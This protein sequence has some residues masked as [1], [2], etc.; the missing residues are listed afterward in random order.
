MRARGTLGRCKRGVGDAVRR[1]LFDNECLRDEYFATSYIVPQKALLGVRALVF[2]Y[3]TAVLISNLAANIVHGAGWNWAA[4]F[5]TLTYSGITAYYGFA[6]YN[7]ARHLARCRG[8]AHGRRRGGV[9]GRLISP[10]IPLPPDQLLLLAAASGRVFGTPAALALRGSS[11]DCERKLDLDHVRLTYPSAHQLRQHSG[12][13][14]EALQWLLR[15]PRKSARHQLSLAA[16]WILYELFTCYAPLVSLVYWA[17]LYPTQGGLDGAA[18]TW[19]GV[20]MHGANT[21]LMGLEVFVFARCPYRWTHVSVV[22]GVLVAYLALVYLMVG[23]YDF[24]VYPFFESKYFG[25][26]GVAVV[27]LLV[28]DVVAIAWVVLLMVHRWRDSAYPRRWLA[29]KLASV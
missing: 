22:M 10:P 14:E 17:V 29:A 20:S 27:C 25:A 12:S 23:V 6:A 16:Q 26:G 21:V 7:T 9:A 1:F 3:C 19:M 18:N 11:G 8:R 5:T 24:Y 28:A 2:V 15:S 4:Y 13:D